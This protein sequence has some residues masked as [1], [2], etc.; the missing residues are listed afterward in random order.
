[1]QVA[2]F[3]QVHAP[4]IQKP[5]MIPADNLGFT[6][7]K[8]LMRFTRKTLHKCNAKS[9]VDIWPKFDLNMVKE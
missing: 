1:M 2:E 6:E 8:I 9:L 3:N 4:K 7:K 5:E